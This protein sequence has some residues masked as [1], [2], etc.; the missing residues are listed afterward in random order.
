MI[1]HICAAVIA[2]L[3]PAFA[4][5]MGYTEPRSDPSCDVNATADPGTGSEHH[6]TSK[7]GG[8]LWPYQTFKSSPLTPPTWEIIKTNDS[9]ASGLVFLTIGDITPQVPITKSPAP[10]IFTDEGQLVWAGPTVNA[11]NF[12]WQMLK[13][14]PVL[15][16]CS[17]QTTSGANVGHGYG[18]ITILDSSYNTTVF[19]PNYGLNTGTDGEFACQAD[20]HESYITDR[21][22]ILVSA[23]NATK[24]GLT[25][26]N[27][28][29]D[30]MCIPHDL[31]THYHD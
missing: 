10:Y 15:T 26:V 1:R 4:S 8:Y 31:A 19:C 3:L 28:T 17:G 16:Y 5:P 7:D 24:T 12:K 30:G 13:D 9:L 14:E 6:G 29:A 2:L 11:T 25:S 21:N 23:Y 20:I 18:N 27:G 22:T